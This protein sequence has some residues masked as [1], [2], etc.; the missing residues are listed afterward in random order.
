MNTRLQVEHPVTELVTGPRPGAAA[1]GDRRRQRACR[2][3]RTDVALERLGHRVPDLRRGPLQRL[4]AL[5]GQTDAAH[6][7]ARAGHPPGRCV[8]DGWTVPME[9]DPLLAKLAV[10][11]ATRE[12]AIGPD[13]PRASRIRRGRDPDQ[14]RLLPPDPGGPR[15][16]RRAT[17]TRASS[18]SSS[19]GSGRSRRR[20]RI[21]LPWPR[22]RR[23]LYT[24]LA[25]GSRA[26]ARNRGAERVAGGREGAICCD[27][28]RLEHQRQ[29]RS[30]SRSLRRRRTAASVCDEARSA[31][32][33]WKWRSRASIPS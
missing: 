6:A 10:W 11:A 27:E 9:Y 31:R 26:A 5:P 1:G 28:T 15:V 18:M 12:E 21:R 19:P 33:K 16:P 23:P 22:W 30:R 13:D 8:Y 17:C 25:R 2:S 3:A 20:R 24:L 32:R 7:A 4:P 29:R 14:H